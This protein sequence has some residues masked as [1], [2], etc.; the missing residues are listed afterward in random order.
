MTVLEAHLSSFAGKAVCSASIP[1]D[2]GVPGWRKGH[3]A[4]IG[5]ISQNLANGI[6]K[7]YVHIYSILMTTML[8]W[9]IALQEL[10]L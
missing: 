9:Y 8:M 6:W 4:A 3:A 10:P 2:Y 7:E 1:F 5:R